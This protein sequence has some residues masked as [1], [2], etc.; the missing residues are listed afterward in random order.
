MA[1]CIPVSGL[2][3]DL[4]K[5]MGG[6]LVKNPDGVY[7]LKG[8][9]AEE[10]QFPSEAA[11]YD[12]LR[13][14]I[15]V[16][17]VNA[18]MHAKVGEAVQRGLDFP[19][20]NWSDIS[21]FAYDM[22]EA[23]DV[24]GGGEAAPMMARLGINKGGPISQ[25]L[26]RGQS[27][28]AAAEYNT[29]GSTNLANGIKREETI[30]EQLE[31]QGLQR[32]APALK[33]LKQMATVRMLKSGDL[34]PQAKELW[35]RVIQPYIDEANEMRDF[36]GIEKDFVPAD[37]IPAW[38]GATSKDIEPKL[39]AAARKKGIL[40]NGEGADELANRLN[41]PHFGEPPRGMAPREWQRH[42]RWLQKVANSI[43]GD[44]QH[45]NAGKGEGYLNDIEHTMVMWNRLVSRESA[46]AATWGPNNERMMNVVDAIGVENPVRGHAVKAGIDAMRGK[47]YRSQQSFGERVGNDVSRFILGS[48][49]SRHLSQN[50]IAIMQ[51]G[52]GKAAGALG[53]ELF[54]AP[55][56]ADDL[57][58]FHALGVTL[59]QS[60]HYLD[61][62]PADVALDR[63]A[64]EASGAYAAMKKYGDM[65]IHLTANAMTKGIH[66]TLNFDRAL[67]GVM[68]KNTFDDYFDRAIAGDRNKLAMMADVFGFG[69]ATT[70]S[71]RA[72]LADH[73]Q[74]GIDRG[75]ARNYFIKRMADIV[76][77]T[78][79]PSDLPGMARWTTE[80][81]FNMGK[82]LVQF[83][84]FRWNVAHNIW[85]QMLSP[86]YSRTYRAWVFGRFL[87]STGT[88]GAIDPILRS[89]KVAGVAGVAAATL[90]VGM[91]NIDS[92]LAYDSF[93][94]AAKNP[95]TSGDL[96]AALMLTVN[97]GSLGI[98]SD[99][100]QGWNMQNPDIFNR[101]IISGNIPVIADV[102]NLAIASALTV[103]GA[104]TG[105][106]KSLDSAWREALADAPLGNAIAKAAG[107]RKDPRVTSKQT[108]R[109]ALQHGA[110]AVGLR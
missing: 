31:L 75:V 15:K 100:V 17:R 45:M 89:M 103:H 78:Y 92:K 46:R 77:T 5:S 60:M 90:G 51:H 35:D 6:E 68:A 11:A 84:G 101:A 14:Q 28:L 79:H 97:D 64:Q 70:A 37:G 38:Y 80:S 59:A 108:I 110:R 29:I 27:W 73:L 49:A 18:E 20:S 47:I 3:G 58:D 55:Q 33:S 72:A 69:D 32:I 13:A 54:H 21:K 65:P 7:V 63:T 81:G 56:I 53:K 36:L 30:G 96:Y 41:A 19:V 107:V 66:Y 99:M 10:R 71:G 87:T 22:A 9:G 67:A 50:K 43:G 44:V 85:N 57:R 94:K 62:H 4:A 95:S 88:I 91:A 40:A 83:R 74:H 104:L 42:Q 23:S 16:H 109:T 12:A 2:A 26:T 48:S 98:G 39:I 24:T 93:E 106:K 8:A 86:N 76:G 52:W 61:E 25:A 1:D 105:D 102:G 34:P 82:W